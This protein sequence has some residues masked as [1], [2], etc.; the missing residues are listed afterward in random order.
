MIKITD[1]KD[2][3]GKTISGFK[4]GLY[5]DFAVISF[6]DESYVTMFTVGYDRADISIC[7]GLQDEEEV[8]LIKAMK[9]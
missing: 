6:T 8:D 1:E 9:E 5:D 2:L 7:Q 4:R 3:I